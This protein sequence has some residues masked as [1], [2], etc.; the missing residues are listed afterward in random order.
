MQGHQDV[1]AFIRAFAGDHRYIVD[2]LVEEVLHTSARPVRSFLLQ[3]SI[4]DRLHGSLCDAVTGQEGGNARLLAWSEATSLS[5]RSMTRAT[6]I[7][8][9]TSLPKCSLRNCWR[10]SPIR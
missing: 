4:L 7:A 8:T 9:T 10:S 5:F 6:G 1:P 2:Y 3:T